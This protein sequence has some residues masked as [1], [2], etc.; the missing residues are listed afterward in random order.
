MYCI[1]YPTDS[2]LIFT[3]GSE[4]LPLISFDQSMLGDATTPSPIMD[5]YVVA[6][7]ESDDGTGR[8]DDCNSMTANAGSY[9]TNTLPSSVSPSPSPSP[10]PPIITSTLPL[11]G[12]QTPS[13]P[14]PYSQGLSSHLSGTSQQ[15]NNQ[16]TT[17]T[18]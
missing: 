9:V 13:P 14:P 10:V 6:N 8:A 3:E 16:P 5:G 11:K 17:N 2:P 18:M 1:I 7:T 4:N 12:T 15:N